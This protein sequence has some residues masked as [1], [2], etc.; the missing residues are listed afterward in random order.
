MMR[1][2]YL[3]PVLGLISSSFA[4]VACSGDGSTSDGDGGAGGEATTPAA[5]GAGGAGDAGGAGGAA[6]STDGTGTL[7][8]EVTG[9]PDGVAPDVSIAGPDSLDALEFGVPA[10]VASGTYTVTGNRVFDEDETVRT[11][12]DATVTAPSFCVN[13]GDSQTITVKYAAVPSSNKLWMPTGLETE[14]FAFGSADLA[15][16]GETEATVG[17][18]G[19]GTKSLAFDRD[20]NLWALGAGD[21]ALVR[22]KAKDLGA[23]GTRAPDI[24]I[25][26]AEVD[27]I[28]AHS[29]I[30]FDPSGNL[31][32]SSIC[33]GE[34]FRLRA[35]DLTTSGAKTADVAI[36]ALFDEG[37]VG[38]SE[39][40]AF[41]REGN[42]WVGGGPA[43][44][45]FDAARLDE[46]SAEPADLELTVKDDL[47]GL[48]GNNLAFDKAGNL[49]ATDW[50]GNVVFQVAESALGQTGS[51]EV[52]ANVSITFGVEAL[53]SQPAFDDGNGLWLGLG[54]GK[55][56]RLSPEQLG[57]SALNVNPDLII[58]ND[59]I[60]SELPFSFFPAPAGLPLYHSLP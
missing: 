51:K 13:D 28:V 14:L 34:V 7:V 24:E 26:L 42:L 50:V 37:G 3:V 8:I 23:T 10:D 27:C 21:H 39:G 41:D 1:L 43:L 55:F 58:S 5:S 18:H 12:Y 25:D 40:L 38:N 52:D 30:A 4:A 49:W 59:G 53:L 2:R 60:T 19:P 15:T 16:E 46:S 57:T 56:G 29:N 31:W 45:R 47:T 9:L 22:F 33:G 17:I 44:R 35:A 20:G 11:V 54:M 6:C 32:I 48:T 36:T